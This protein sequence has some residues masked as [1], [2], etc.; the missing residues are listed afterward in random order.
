M[1]QG[2]SMIAA[3]AGHA[4]PTAQSAVCGVAQCA[5]AHQAFLHSLR[6][7]DQPPLILLHLGDPSSLVLQIPS[8]VVLQGP[9]AS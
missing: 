3:R 7:R 6:L 1:M 9:S 5:S 8:F 2:I 4:V